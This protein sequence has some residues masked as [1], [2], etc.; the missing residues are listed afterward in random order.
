MNYSLKKITQRCLLGVIAVLFFYSCGSDE[1]KQ[2]YEV[3]GVAQGT[4]YRV[5]YEDTKMRK[6]EFDS[7]LKNFD[8]SFSVYIP[9]SLIS[10]INN[11]DTS[12]HSIQNWEFSYFYK[13]SQYIASI[14][15]S[16]FDITV[17]PL[18]NAWKFGPDTSKHL[19]PTQKQIDSIREFVGMDKISMPNDSS[20]IKS[21]PR[22]QIIGNAIAQGYSSDLIAYY[23][24]KLGVENYLVDVGCEMRSKGVNAKGNVWT[25]GITRPEEKIDEKPLESSFDVA[26]EL[27]NRSLATSG[28][29]RKFYYEDGRKYSHTINPKTGQTVPSDLLSATIFATECIEADAIA[30]ACMVMGVEKSKQFFVRHPEYDALLI[31]DGGDSLQT[32]STKGVVVKK[33]HD[34]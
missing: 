2:Y 12:I 23:L 24:D 3:T 21:D 16:A 11:N 31:Y 29:Y 18:V 22:V 27:K 19:V 34:K 10:R 13:K 4:Y 30:T 9:E 8:T 1:K 6:P 7:L 15:D 20:F 25:I 5:I 32:Y 28:N 33:I 26:V 17:A 14:T